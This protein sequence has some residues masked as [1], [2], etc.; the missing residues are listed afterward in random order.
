[1]L[2]IL[3]CPLLLLPFLLL[4]FSLL[5]LFCIVYGWKRKKEQTFK[6]DFKE[7][8]KRNKKGREK[9]IGS[10]LLSAASSFMLG[11]LL[12]FLLCLS[13]FPLSVAFV[14]YGCGLLLLIIVVKWQKWEIFAGFFGLMVERR[15]F[16]ILVLFLGFWRL[17]R[18]CWELAVFVVSNWCKKDGIFVCF[19]DLL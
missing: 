4:A 7:K 17:G 13:C 2:P 6:L 15:A 10:S 3:V 9:I 1:M 18:W 11:T 5:L 8:K 19:L 14:C 12:S 16:Y